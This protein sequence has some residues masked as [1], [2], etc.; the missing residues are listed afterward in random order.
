MI[1]KIKHPSTAAIIG[2]LFSLIVGI[3]IFAI[4]GFHLLPTLQIG[5]LFLSGI[6]LVL[7]LIP[8]F[9]ALSLDDTSRVV[10]LFQFFPIFV[11]IISYLFLH[12][13]LN[14][15]QLFGFAFITIGG[16][17]LGA[18][19][20]DKKIFSI[21]KSFW[22]MMLSSLLY[23]FTGIIFKYLPQTDFW[24]NISYQ[25]MGIGIGALLLF[26][27][28]PYRRNFLQEIKTFDMKVYKALALNTGLTLLAEFSYFFAITLAPVALISI[29][30]G[31]QPLFVLLYGLILTLWLPHLI[32][33]DIRRKTL[34]LKLLS[35]ILLFVG[36]YF[37]Y[38]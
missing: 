21:R 7:Y 31:T 18:K 29:A 23:S 25:T 1:K 11:L 33:E 37:I 15:K 2:G 17:L 30:Q 3:V 13:S 16:F 20:I 8:Y 4:R 28:T 38:L 22:Y 14:G 34:E 5:L 24:L 9:K 19:Q 10:P 32:K 12:E 36:I 26:L 35:I 27:Y 6:L